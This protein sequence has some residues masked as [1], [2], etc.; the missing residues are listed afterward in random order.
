MKKEGEGVREKM[1]RARVN[2]RPKMERG[3]YSNSDI[4]VKIN[5]KSSN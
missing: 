4:E 5:T 1:Y 3:K 2:G